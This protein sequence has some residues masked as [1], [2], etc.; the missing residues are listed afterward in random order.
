MSHPSRL[1]P[2][3]TAQRMFLG[4]PTEKS[5]VFSQDD[6]IRSGGQLKQTQGLDKIM[7]LLG[8]MCDGY[9]VVRLSL[10]NFLGTW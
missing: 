8:Q 2:D 6:G 5:K 7:F 9:I 10:D 4:Q 3:I 1:L